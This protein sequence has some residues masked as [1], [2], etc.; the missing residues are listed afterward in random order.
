MNEL[1]EQLKLL[2]QSQE[3]KQLRTAKGEDYGK[4]QEYKGWVNAIDHILLLISQI[5]SNPKI[6][7]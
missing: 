2:R 7:S 5:D 6:K 4:A 1:K 3:E